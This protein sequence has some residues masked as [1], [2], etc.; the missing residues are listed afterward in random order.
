M[1]EPAVDSPDLGYE[2][3]LR[4]TQRVRKKVVEEFTNNGTVVPRD[5]K[6]V[7][8]LLKALDGMDRTALDERKNTIDQGNA[9]TSK[10]VADALHVFI[11]EQKNTNPF[12]R[13]PNNPHGVIPQIDKT[14]LG[15]FEIK[16]GEKEIGISTES[17]DNFLDRMSRQDSEDDE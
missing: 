6:E 15:E 4:Y 10:R 14:L 17:A 2:G 9:D 1:S 13:D 3:T 7:G 5:T 8:V 12:K 16:P 11:K